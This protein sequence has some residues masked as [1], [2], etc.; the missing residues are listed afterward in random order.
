MALA[1][2]AYA[3]KPKP[4]IP[5]PRTARNATQKRIVKT[6]RARYASLVRVGAVL[7]LVLTGLMA[8]VMLTSNVTSLTY[9]V[10]KAHHQRDVLQQQTAILAD[11]IATASSDERLAAMARKLQMSDPQLFAVVH[12]APQQIS[13]SHLAV[14]D[15]IAGWFT[16][17][18]RMQAH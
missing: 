9:A 3:P 12:L 8:Y 16:P 7:A 13:T 10:A 2:P 17:T 14:I 5:N 15:S 1:Q 4:R 11:R 18:S 6:N